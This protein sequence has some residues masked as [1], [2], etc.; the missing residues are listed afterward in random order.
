M[1]HGKRAYAF[2]S[3]TLWNT[4]CFGPLPTK[5]LR[6]CDVALLHASSDSTIRSLDM[7]L[8][9]LQLQNSHERSERSPGN[10]RSASL[11]PRSSAPA[12]GPRRVLR[13]AAHG[14]KLAFFWLPGAVRSALGWTGQFLPHAEQ[15]TSL[16]L[17]SCVASCVVPPR[18]GRKLKESATWTVTVAF[19]AQL[20]F[21]R[22]C[23]RSAKPD[24][25]GSDAV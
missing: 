24:S 9:R 20:A 10:I 8:R 1:A 19:L 2:R 21:A 7:Q 13:C 11:L 12:L 16:S 3:L 22:S 4:T 6:Y 15:S 17:S 5:L 25:I 18:S 23:T 14:S